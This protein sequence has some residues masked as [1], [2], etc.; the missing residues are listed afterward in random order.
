[1][2]SKVAV[3]GDEGLPSEGVAQGVATMLS[4]LAWP[5]YLVERQG[6]LLYSNARG[7]GLIGETL[8]ITKN[9]DGGRL[10]FRN[11]VADDVYRRLLKSAFAQA[12]EA[13]WRMRV[14]A[15]MAIEVCRLGA[16]ELAVVSARLSTPL[17]FSAERL[18]GM[19]A[20]PPMQAEL[21]RELLGGGTLDTFAKRMGITRRTAKHHIDKLKPKF[22]CRKQTEL[23]IKL[24]LMLF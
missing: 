19:L 16:G 3:Y 11:G 22:G 14:D 12:G 5:A 2:L 21:A 9:C 24:C 23:V 13:V 20:V 10:E 1:M 6:R 8:L 18:V 7:A 4:M 15:D 17:E